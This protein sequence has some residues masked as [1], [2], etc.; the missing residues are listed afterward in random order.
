MVQCPYIHLV[1]KCFSTFVGG[2]NFISLRFDIVIVVTLKTT[3]F[4]G[5]TLCSLVKKLLM[6]PGFVVS[7]S[8]YVG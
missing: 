7:V 5:L 1:V 6:F 3:V 8:S 4:Q 2:E